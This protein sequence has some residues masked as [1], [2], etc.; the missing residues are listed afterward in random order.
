M[1]GCKTSKLTEP[2]GKGTG[3]KNFSMELLGEIVLRANFHFYILIPGYI[4]CSYKGYFI[5]NCPEH[6]LR[7][8]NQNH[9]FAGCFLLAVTLFSKGHSMVLS[10]LFPGDGIEIRKLVQPIMLKPIL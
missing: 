7:P 3:S 1:F 10:N 2:K 4:K 6:V 8:L 9:M 5:S